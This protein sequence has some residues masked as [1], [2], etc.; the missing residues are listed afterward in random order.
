MLDGNDMIVNLTTIPAFK[1]IEGI[2]ICQ[3]HPCDAEAV[4]DFI[5][6]HFAA[7]WIGEARYAMMQDPVRCFIA[8]ENKRVVGFACYDATAKDYFGPIGVH[9]D[10]QGRG[11]GTQLMLKTL[12]AMRAY[13]YGYAVIGWVREAAPFYKKVLGAEYIKG[14]IPENSI[15][16]RLISM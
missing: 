12:E 3:M 16:N 5:R 11:V 7:G 10:M 14:G 6:E 2:K 1:E 13:G 4:L 15:Y 8:V 9:P